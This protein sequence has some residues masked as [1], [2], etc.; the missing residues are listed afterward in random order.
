MRML[1]SILVIT[2]LSSCAT[3]QDP[4]DPNTGMTKSERNHCEATRS[5]RPYVPGEC[6][7]DH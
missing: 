2:L 4:V 5:Y 6:G 1:I 7:G 3:G